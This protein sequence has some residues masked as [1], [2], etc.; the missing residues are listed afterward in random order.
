MSKVN[1]R[2]ASSFPRK[3]EFDSPEY[4]EYREYIKTRVGSTGLS[5]CGTHKTA[6][7]F[8]WREKHKLEFQGCRIYLPKDWIPD[9]KFL[10]VMIENKMFEGDNTI[11]RPIEYDEEDPSEKSLNN[12]VY[13][14]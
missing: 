10:E 1:N 12:S 5:L 11:I 4:H 2:K 7:N 9:D 13:K 14:V 3:L 6:Y 8:F